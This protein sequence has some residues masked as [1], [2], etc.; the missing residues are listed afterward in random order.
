MD[1][2]WEGSR[3]SFQLWDQSLQACTLHLPSLGKDDGTWGPGC[4]YFSMAVSSDRS[5]MLEKGFVVKD[6]YV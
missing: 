5:P 3:A 1:H 4:L 6:N 2:Q